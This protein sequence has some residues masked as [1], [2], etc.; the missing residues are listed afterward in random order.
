MF[1]SPIPDHL[2][3]WNTLY[4]VGVWKRKIGHGRGV[5]IL[6]PCVDVLSLINKSCENKIETVKYRENNREN[7]QRISKTKKKN[8]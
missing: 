3:H 5:V 1:F 2:S 4:Y 6:Q 7:E 8:K